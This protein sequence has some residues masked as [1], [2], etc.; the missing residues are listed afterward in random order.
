[1]SFAM[2]KSW[3]LIFPALTAL[4]IA[5]CGGSDGPS[6]DQRQVLTP[7]SAKY[8]PLMIS[9]HMSIG[10]NRFVVGLLNQED[11]TEVLGATLH[12]RFFIA[13][14]SGTTPKFEA[15]PAVIV[16]K[17]NYTHTH[18]DGTIETHE[19]GETGAYVSH[20]DFGQAGVW[21][22]E[23]SGTTKQ[24]E[25]LEPVRL[26][27]DVLATD[28][29][30]AIGSAV[31]PSKQTILADVSDIREIDTSQDPIPEEHNM[32]VADAIASGRP[33]VIA[34]ATP[35]FCQSQVC[36]PTKE[37]FDALYR[38]YSEQ[39][40]FIHIEPYDV[41]RLRDGTCPSLGECAVPATADFRLETEPWVFIADARGR[42][43][44]KFEGI[45]SDTELE[46]ALLALPG[47]SPA[48]SDEP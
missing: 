31:P 40:N 17:K 45:T 24:G 34:F 39:A 5:G 48:P 30:I 32:T 1:M 23:V 13:A 28:P 26:Q 42:L 43:S 15:D 46:N 9:S 14:D 33:S 3:L 47:I 41:K 20:V 11:N 6:D 36:G 35:A 8:L 2:R 19:A 10:D 29:G 25:Q 38:K 18:A 21:N 37:I 4:L 27:F 22:V 7:I 44:A 12:L 16:L